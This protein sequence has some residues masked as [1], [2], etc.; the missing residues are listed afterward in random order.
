MNKKTKT[1]TQQRDDAM[2]FALAVLQSVEG[3]PALP[4]R[5][6]GEVRL[7]VDKLYASLNGIPEAK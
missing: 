4:S 5:A 6:K 1:F 3:C 7:A 2:N